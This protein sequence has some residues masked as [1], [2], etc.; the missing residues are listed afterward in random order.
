MM[1]TQ[2]LH[3]EFEPAEGALL[4]LIGLIERRGYAVQRLVLP[5]RTKGCMALDLGLKSNGAGRD[6]GV[7]SR[8]I[9]RLV[10]VRA[11]RS[12]TPQNPAATP[13]GESHGTA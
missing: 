7:L 10:G 1:N 9:R 4:R 5:V 2:S 11:V 8:Q 6:I 3:I 12:S 13:H